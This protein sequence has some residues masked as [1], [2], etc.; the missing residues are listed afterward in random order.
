MLNIQDVQLEQTRVYQDI[1]VKAQQKL[2]LRLLTNRLGDVPEPL[3]A[4]ILTMSLEQ[5]EQLGTAY[6]DFAGLGDLEKWLT[7]SLVDQ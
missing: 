7:D 5:I 4:K 3:R 6:P 2:I 1:E